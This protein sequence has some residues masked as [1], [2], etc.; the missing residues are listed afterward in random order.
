M[1]VLANAHKSLLSTLRL[2]YSASFGHKRDARLSEFNSFLVETNEFSSEWSMEG[3]GSPHAQIRARAVLSLSQRHT[4]RK[5]AKK[6]KKD[7]RL[8][9]LLQQLHLLTNY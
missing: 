2:I 6:K 9:L 7:Q 4:R 1:I 5:C 8:N 3:V